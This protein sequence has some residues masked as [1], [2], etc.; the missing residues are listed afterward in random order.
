MSKDYYKTLGVAKTASA[1]EIKKAHRKLARKHHPDLNPGDKKAEE[2]FKEIQ[3]AYDVL[4]DEAKRAKFDQFGDGWE[5]VADGFPQGGGRQGGGSAGGGTGGFGGGTPFGGSVG[6]S[7]VNFQDIFEHMF[8]S[9]GTRGKPG[10][11]DVRSTPREYVTPSAAPAEDIDFGLDITLEEAYTGVARRINVTVEDVCPEC[12]GL[13]Q[14]RNSKGQIDLSNATGCP[15][16]RG[17]GRVASPRSSQV[18]VPPGAWDGMRSKLPGMGAADARGSRG[19]M[20]VQLRVLPNTKFERDGQNLLFDVSVP[21]TVAALGGEINVETLDKQTRQLVV[22]AGIQTGQ[23]MRLSGKGMPALRDRKA[24]DAYARVKI[25][26]PRDLSDQERDL[27]TQL[28]RL[29]N[30]PVRSK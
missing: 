20:Y 25:T 2:K 23:K 9:G 18:N 8:G 10:F 12:E 24:G 14:K 17:T 28:A 16:C 1:E 27:L 29:R 13:G 30:D 6:E 4:S 5:Q 11:R 21:Y 26:V 3:E 15:R 7:G 22:P 19:D